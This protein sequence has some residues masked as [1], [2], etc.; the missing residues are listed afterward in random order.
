MA[1]TDIPLAIYPTYDALLQL[2]T[3]RDKLIDASGERVAFI[4]EAPATDSLTGVEFYIDA[5]TTADDLDI[6]IETVTKTTATG[7]EP[8]GTLWAANT[9]VTLLSGSQSAASWHSVTLTSSAS[10]TLGDMFAVVIQWTSDTTASGNLEIRSVGNG[11]VYFPIVKHRTGG[12]WASD[13]NARPLLGL[14]FGGT[15]YPTIGTASFTTS[16]ATTVTT[17][18]EFGIKFTPPFDCR[19]IGVFADT[20]M[21]TG[22]SYTVEFYTTQAPGAG[23]Q[24]RAAIQT[25]TTSNGLHALM[26]D[27]QQTLNAGTSYRFTIAPTASTNSFPVKLTY[28]SAALM[29]QDFGPNWHYCEDNGA[30][31][32][33]DTTTDSLLYFGLL[34]DQLDDGAGGGGSQ[35]ISQG[36]HTIDSSIIA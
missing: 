4:V 12:S 29:E 17:G 20:R 18:R 2:G 11:I 3:L 7:Y 27:T 33:T 28:N 30:G 22:I 35:G 16:T 23:T 34:L 10:L 31:G 36:L 26:L 32:W 24:A 14:N 6:R 1:L 21:G 15:Y 19:V 13:T 8:T 25:V 5:L 9:N